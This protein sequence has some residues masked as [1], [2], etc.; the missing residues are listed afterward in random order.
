MLFSFSMIHTIA[1]ERWGLKPGQFVARFS[2][3]A[4][5]AR[6][7]LQLVEQLPAVSERQQLNQVN[8]FVHEHV[9]Y[10]TD[11]ALYGQSDYWASVSET[12]EQGLG[13]CEDYAIA[14]YASLRLAGVSD[15]KLRLVYVRARIG[16]VNSGVSQAHMVLGYYPTP[17]SE[18]LILDSLISDILPASQR[19]DLTPVF[20]FN[21]SG[22]WVGAAGQQAKT[23]PLDRLSRW[24]SVLDRL[25]D[26]GIR[27]QSPRSNEGAR[28]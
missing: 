5:T 25:A 16:G 2:E 11:Q 1:N 24:R 7:W 21:A 8:R 12:F 14:Q 10:R 6:E 3:N 26:E 23:S 20:S 15:D 18:P 9:R 28:Q 17:N 4:D 27:W 19:P 22:L 13:D